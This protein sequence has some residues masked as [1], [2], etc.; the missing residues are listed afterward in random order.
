M[1]DDYC[2]RIYNNHMNND[3][4]TEALKAFD[5]PDYSQIPDVGLYLE[6]V[7]RYING[8]LSGYPEMEVTTS[9][10]SNYAKQ[11]LIDRVNRKTYT[12]RQIAA[13]IFIVM[14]KTVLSIDKI[15]SILNELR[16][17]GADPEVYYNEFRQRLLHILS[18]F[19][20]PDAVLQKS[21]LRGTD[22]MLEN[23]AVTIGHKM[24]LE[25]YF[26]TASAKEE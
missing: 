25:Q 15:R 11:K 23:I 9:M 14:T 2:H 24:Y 13:L 21:T 4:L 18:G 19:T 26:E 7:A 12:R 16:I 10:I 20:D 5:L 1:F 6:Q 17:S 22:R 8:Y 3:K